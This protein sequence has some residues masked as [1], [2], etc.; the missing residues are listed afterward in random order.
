MSEPSTGLKTSAGASEPS[1]LVDWVTLLKPRI[2]S[3]VA[4][5]AYVGGWL[6]SDGNA[7]TALLIELSFYV[8]LTGGAA[9]IFNQVI[10]RD[11]DAL[12]PRTANRPLP[13]GRISVRDAIA[14]AAV[15]A[16]VGT[17]GLGLRFEPLSAVLALA[18]IVAYALVYTPLKRHTS[19]NTLVG[20]LP[21]AMPPLL[22]Y[23]AIAGDGGVWGWS[24]FAVLFVW[25]FPHFMAIAWLYREDYA[26]GGMK[27]LPSLPGTEGMAGRQALLYSVVILPAALLPLV[28]GEGTIVYAVGATAAGLAYVAASIAFAMDENVVSAKRLLRTSLL[29]LPVIFALAIFDRAVML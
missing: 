14:A 13:T 3:F 28:R 7:S 1:V 16:T 4:L 24:L 6:A 23:A 15:M 19:F 9:G 22:G 20:A 8:T 2:S 12:M 18:T 21:G 27:M 11:T 5:A 25:Q 29:Y 10:E 17:V 26:A